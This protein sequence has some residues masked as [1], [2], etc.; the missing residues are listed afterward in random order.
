MILLRF[1][2][3]SSRMLLAL[4]MTTAIVGGACNA[5]LIA[6]LNRALHA[7]ASETGRL[8]LLFAVLA[9]ARIGAS[10]LSQLSLARFTQQAIAGLRRDLVAT[11]MRVPLADLERL[12][13]GR[14]M[15]SLSD[16]AMSVTDGLVGLPLL[17]VNLGLLACGGLYLAWLS[18]QVVLW[19]GLFV[20]VGAVVHR[21]LMRSGLR[22]LRLARDDQDRLFG[23]F[24][25]LTEGMKELKLHRR[26]RSQ[27]LE[28]GVEAVTRSHCE[29]S[30]AAESRFIATTNF[31]NLLFLGLIGV[32]AFLVPRFHPLDPE[33]L[34]GF[35]L[36]CPFLMGPLAAV[37]GSFS[38]LGRASVALERVQALGL[39]LGERATER[40][41]LEER[42]EAKSFERLELKGVA[43]TYRSDTD[44]RHFQLG[45]I[46]LTVRPGELVFV[47]G[48][49]G[50]GKSTLAKM[51]TGLYAPESGTIRVD[52]RAID[53]EADRDHYRQL[54][55]A[56]FSD[57]FL[58]ED[59]PALQGADTSGLAREYL[60]KLRLDRKVKIEGGRFSTTALSSGQRKRL[61]LLVSYLED[62]PFYV[63][64]EWAA[65][66]DPEFKEVFYTGL[67]PELRARQ[68]AVLVITHDDRYFYV[69]DRL[70]K[71]D[72]GQMIE[73][74]VPRGPRLVLDARST[75]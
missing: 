1:I 64:D 4:V 75:A 6:T 11:I 69:A 9:A 8:A 63:F 16:D 66:Q 24:R 23:H 32:V 14:L 72:S 52:G 25:A 45:P 7:P 39:T 34:S 60:Q 15:A 27:F 57:F 71:L 48:G 56:V 43:H 67:L 2:L 3:K 36:T 18:W 51:L 12:G 62:R 20:M 22:F 26:R 50:S 65:D 74:E 73:S 5:G 28:N 47:V 31:S 10:V 21:M 13:A 30:V 59:L 61:A 53:S 33:T 17:M 54:F 40:A 41:V 35:V 68:K 42:P 29:N 46:D 38:Y 19:M 37:L 44:D 55:S 70:L 49:N 58:F